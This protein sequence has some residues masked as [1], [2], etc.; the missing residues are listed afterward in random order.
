MRGV[1]KQV[2]ESSNEIFFEVV[3]VQPAKDEKSV[4]HVLLRI[5]GQGLRLGR[6]LLKSELITDFSS[7]NLLYADDHLVYILPDINLDE[8]TIRQKFR[9]YS[10]IM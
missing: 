3:A 5:E 7:S 1:L 10:D 2:K 6:Q 4:E 9:N 8:K